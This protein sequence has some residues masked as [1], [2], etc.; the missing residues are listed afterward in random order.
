VRVAKGQLELEGPSA[1]GKQR[2]KCREC[3]EELA[4]GNTAG[5]QADDSVEQGHAGGG[6]ERGRQRQRESAPQRGRRKC[7]HN[8]Q[9]NKCKD[10]GGASICEHNRIRSRCKDCGGA[11]ICEHNRIRSPSTP[12]YQGLPGYGG[13]LRCMLGG[14]HL[15]CAHHTPQMPSYWQSLEA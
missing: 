15:R 3:R 12:P 2:G 9:R 5:Q 7:E 14:G 1:G 13:H 8:R 6:W 10:C 4:D 11:S